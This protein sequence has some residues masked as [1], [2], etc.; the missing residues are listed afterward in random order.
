[1]RDLIGKFCFLFSRRELSYLVAL[2]FLSALGAVFEVLGVGAIPTFMILV[3]RPQAIT[4]Y[5]GVQRLLRLMNLRIGPDLFLWA[6]LGLVLLFILKNAYLSLLA[7]GK[8][9]FVLNRQIHIS[10]RLFRA[11][12]FSPY[13]FHL[14][15]NSAA[16]TRNV[17][18]EVSQ[19]LNMVLMPA[20][21]IAMEVLVI[22]FTAVLAMTVEPVAGALAF[23]LLG[24]A[25]GVYM[26][27]IRKR[28]AYYG[29]HQ[30]QLGKRMVQ[31]IREG[32]GAYRDAKMLGREEYF[33]NA[34]RQTSSE[35]ARTARFRQIAEDFPTR[36][37]EI[38]AVSGMLLVMFVLLKGAADVQS[39][40]PTL[41]LFG[42]A[43]VRLLPSVNRVSA[44]VS[45]IRFCR[46][47]VDAIYDDIV[48]L[49]KPSEF[50]S[51]GDVKPLPLRNCVEMRGVHY[52]YPGAHDDALKGIS[53]T[54]KKGSSVAFVGPSGSGK[55]TLVNLILGLLEPTNGVIEV[56]GSDL[57][58]NLRGWQRNIGYVPQ[59][60]YLTDDTVRKNV[61]FGLKESEIDPRKLDAAIEAAQLRPFLQSLPNGLDTVV[62]E[63]GVRLSGGQRQRIGIARAIYIDPE[64]LV[65]DEATSSLDNET[66]QYIIEAIGALK[67]NRTIIMIAHRLSTVWQCDELFFI[68]NGGIQNRGTYQELATKDAEF[69]RM[70]TLSATQ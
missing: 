31:D 37:I 39:V 55:T 42:V 41:V 9:R 3:I 36:F 59:A 58:T 27:F 17:H 43:A 62:G 30:Q 5:A 16:L 15:T 32:I 47:S 63:R 11:Y 29:M 64:L 23:L 50:G 60:I 38:C 4:T 7:Y 13:T 54:I 48:H 67:G 46:Y 56:D 28:L 19:A 44:A 33:V 14:Q 57:R 26:Y 6:S 34:V 61:A 53:L 68:K 10:E 2:Y 21:T 12:L 40:V 1:M 20:L 25:S 35:F 22:A 45:S 18:I 66:E 8:S 52:R 65:L 51:R 69:Q 24:S 70:V 49:E